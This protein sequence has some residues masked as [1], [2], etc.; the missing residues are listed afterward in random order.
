M[1]Q[2]TNAPFSIYITIDEIKDIF[3]Y[4][5]LHHNLEI[6]NGIIF[7]HCLMNKMIKSNYI[8]EMA[9]TCIQYHYKDLQNDCLKNYHLRK[10]LPANE[11]FLLVNRSFSKVKIIQAYNIS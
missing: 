2:S 6:L 9:I 11:G 8:V 1:H 10:S 5:F 7:S 3:C 4:T